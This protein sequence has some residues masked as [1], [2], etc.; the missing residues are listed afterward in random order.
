LEAGTTALTGFPGEAPLRFDIGAGRGLAFRL[1]LEMRFWGLETSKDRR[2]GFMFKRL[3]RAIIGS[4]KR[5]R[6]PPVRMMVDVS[7]TL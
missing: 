4:V 3:M 5:L 2:V 7:A 1:D 6:Q